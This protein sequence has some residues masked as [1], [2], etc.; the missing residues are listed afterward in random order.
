MKRI[1]RIA[2]IALALAAFAA[3]PAVAQTVLR[4]SHTDTA[5]GSR[6]A[7]AE[8]FAR[9]VEQYT[10]GRYRVQVFHSGQL[11]NDPKAIEMLQLGGLDFTVSGTGSYATHNRNLNLTAMPYLVDS[12]EQGWKFY[13]E[14]PWLAA[15]FAKLPARGMRILATWEA[16]FRSFT[17][18]TE[19]RSPADARGQKM[20]VFPNDMIRWI[21][22]SMGFTT[23]VMPVTEVYLG[24]QQGTVI[25]QE[26]PTDTIFS[27]RFYEVAPFITLTRHVYSPLPL[28][29]A[30][31][32]WQ[33][34][35]PADRA[36]VERAAKES[37]QMSRQLVR[38]DENKQLD[39]MR[40]KGARVSTP[41]IAAW[42]AAVQPVYERARGVYGA[43][44]DAVL[45]AAEAIRAS[46]RTN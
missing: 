36:A 12:Y 33:R 8:D 41:D 42:R 28:A 35:S 15:E 13:D 20:R 44:V 19:L 9:K 4:F 29:V 32:T 17:T 22:E 37:A 38:Q 46:T 40:A 43:D 27:L 10:Q 5:V 1:A 23:V 14:S 3:A 18:K 31:S 11:A 2:G 26:N 34:L 25:G 6:Q 39:E 45:R 21:M 7:A 16:G 24:I 30:E